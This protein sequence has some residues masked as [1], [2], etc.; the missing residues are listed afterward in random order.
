MSHELGLGEPLSNPLKPSIDIVFVHGL[1]G[2][3]EATW[4]HEQSKVFWPK[5]L[6]PRDIEDARIHSFGYNAKVVDWAEPPSDATIG[7]HAGSLAARLVGLRSRT[8]TVMLE[9]KEPSARDMHEVRQST[10]FI[11]FFGTPF[12]GSKQANFANIFTR[13]FSFVKRT[14]TSYVRDLDT[15]SAIGSEFKQ[16]LTETT[17]NKI[18][19]VSF[20]E[21]SCMPLPAEKIVTEDSARIEPF[22]AIVIPGDHKQMCKFA[23]AKDSGYVLVLGVLQDWASQCRGSKGLEDLGFGSEDRINVS[24]SGENK[25]SMVGQQSFSG[26]ASQNFGR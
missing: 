19:I 6:L 20:F 3:R 15:K 16:W 10:R 9:A 4:T 21:E 12:Y 26:N 2:G 17:V 8:E 5:D 14:N 22:R 1:Y 13:L 24:N 23:S 11:A 25:G 7:M 18:E